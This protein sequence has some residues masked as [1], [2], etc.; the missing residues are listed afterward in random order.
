MKAAWGTDGL[1]RFRDM[2]PFKVKVMSM[3]LH[4]HTWHIVYEELD[5]SSFWG[6]KTQILVPAPLVYKH[7]TRGGFFN[8]SEPLFP[9][10]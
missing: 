8:C 2:W 5:G 7:V 10:L 9:D 4:T 6:Q 3:C 1:G